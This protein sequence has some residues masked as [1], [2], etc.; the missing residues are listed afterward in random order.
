M[1]TSSAAKAWANAQLFSGLRDFSEDSEALCQVLFTDLVVSASQQHQHISLL[2]ADAAAAAP[3]L[4]ADLRFARD[5]IDNLREALNKKAATGFEMND[6]FDCLLLQDTIRSRMKSAKEALQEA[7]NWNSLTQELDELFD[8]NDFDKAAKRLAEASRS[9]VLLQG[10]PEYEDRRTL[11]HSLQNQLYQAVLPKLMQAFEEHDDP[12]VSHLRTL[13]DHIQRPDD[14]RVCYFKAAKA[15]LLLEWRRVNDAFAMDSGPGFL[16]GLDKF[17]SFA[18][19]FLRNEIRWT[20]NLFPTEIP[21][22]LIKLIHQTFNSLKPSLRF[23]LDRL[24]SSPEFTHTLADAFETS[25]S[26]CVSIERE[27]ISLATAPVALPVASQSVAKRPSTL[28]LTTSTHP[29][30]PHSTTAANASSHKIDLTTWAF[31]FLEPF[32]PYHQTY[33]SLVSTY[34]AARLSDLFTVARGAPQTPQ[35]SV[36][37]LRVTMDAV[38]DLVLERVWETVRAVLKSGVRFTAGFASEAFVAVVDSFLGMVVNRMGAVVAGIAGLGGIPEDSVHE[39]V[40]F[41]GDGKGEEEEDEFGVGQQQESDGREWAAFELGVR[42]L[43]VLKGFKEGLEREEVGLRGL[44]GRERGRMVDAL[45]G[46]ERLE[47]GGVDALVVAEPKLESAKGEAVKGVEAAKPVENASVFDCVSAISLFQKSALN[48][49]DAINSFYTRVSDPSS[50]TIPLFPVATARLDTLVHKTQ[51]TLFDVL[52]LPI[53]KHLDTVS[54]LATWSLEVDPTNAAD[55]MPFTS[56]SPSVFITRVGETVLTLPQRFDM[57][58]VGGSG[59]GGDGGG[60]A[61]AV[62]FGVRGLPHLE[63]SD[64][65][66]AGEEEGGL[67]LEDV[68]HLWITSLSRHLVHELLEKVYVIPRLGRG[69]ARQ[70]GTDVDYIVRVLEAMDVQVGAEVAEVKGWVE[71]FVGGGVEGLREGVREGGEGGGKGEVG[72]K[73]ARICGIIE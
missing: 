33:A 71:V 52:F 57:H 44:L 43:G 41:V 45:R 18:L 11:L 5:D 50:E 28:H 2:C 64:F 20:H 49:P 73:V 38:V 7:E 69:G 26:W 46:L 15:P 35:A 68:V 66:G 17:L 59:G 29:T 54:G 6:A 16:Q 47:S 55:S 9:L 8:Q 40:V 13:F 51:T 60:E 63:E 31:P 30:L 62:G 42:L 23:S 72:R 4:S 12:A 27:L 39:V 67:L 10:T 70:L 36:A 61:G 32:C 56:L 22:T 65:E 19:E 48:T 21:A 3:R 53:Q 1:K 25:V 24:K 34:L 14:F 37:R 58:M